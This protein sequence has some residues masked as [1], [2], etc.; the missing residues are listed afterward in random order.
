MADEEKTPN[1]ARKRPLVGK[2]NNEEV[3]PMAAASLGNNAKEEN[4]T[5]PPMQRRQGNP[6]KKKPRQLDTTPGDVEVISPPPPRVALKRPV[7]SND[8]E[9]CV[10]QSTLTNALVEYPHGR[11]DCGLHSFSEDKSKFCDKCYCLVCNKLA[12]QC[13]DWGE[14]CS[15]ENEKQKNKRTAAPA[16]HP[17]IDIEDSS[18]SSPE[19]PANNLRSIGNNKNIVNP[20]ARRRHQA[21]GSAF[22][23]FLDAQANRKGFEDHYTN[24][25]NTAYENP[26]EKGRTAKSMKITE[27]L[28]QKLAETMQLADKIPSSAEAT[29][30]S[31]TTAANKMNNENNKKSANEELTTHNLQKKDRFD[32]CK[33]EGD[34]A[35]LGLHKSFFVEGVRIGWPYPSILTPQRLMAIH[36]VKAL[37]NSRHVVLESPTGTGK[38]AAI[39]CAVLAWQRH[40]A[41]SNWGK[42]V[43]SNGNISALAA[44]KMHLEPGAETFPRIIYCSRTHSQVAQMVASLKKTPYRPRMTVLG[45]RDRLCI[46]R[47][48]RNK[49]GAT[50]G[51]NGGDQN[52]AKARVNVNT[53]CQMRVANAEKIR[54]QLWNSYDFRYDDNRPPSH[55]PGDGDGNQGD[56]ASDGED[57][58][59]GDQMQS[60]EWILKKSKK[61]LTCPHYRQLSSYRTAH[62]TRNRFAA[63]Q[64]EIQC[65]K[66][67]GEKTKLGVHE[68]ED[69]CS[70]GVNPYIIEVALYRNTGSREDFG[71]IIGNDCRIRSIGKDTPAEYCG[72]LNR[73]DKIVLVNGKQAKSMQHIQHE[74]ASTTADVVNLKVARSGSSGTRTIQTRPMNHSAKNESHRQVQVALYR[75][76][77]ETSFGMTLEIFG[78]GC[79]IS[80]FKAGPALRSR[81]V[82]V[83]DVITG[84]NGKYLTGFHDVTQEILNTAVDPLR[85]N[86]RRQTDV[87]IDVDEASDSDESDPAESEDLYSPHS[88]CPYY[89]SRALS[90]HAELLF[91]PYNYILDPGIRKALEIDLEGAVVV[92]DEAHNVEGT[93]TESGS[94]KFGEIELT[95]LFAKLSF[96]SSAA[97]SRSSK[98][99]DVT[100]SLGG[101]IDLAE[102]AH[103][104]LLFVEK[105]ILYMREQRQRFEQSPGNVGA[106]KAIEDYQRFHTPDNTDFEVSY[107]GP[108]GHGVH[109]KAVGCKPFF[110]LDSMQ[111]KPADIEK[112]LGY[113]QELE[114]QL[115]GSDKA[116]ANESN[117]GDVAGAGEKSPKNNT[118]DLLNELL[119]KFQLASQSPQHFYIS[120][121]IQANGNFDHAAG[122]LGNEDRNNAGTRNRRFQKKPANLPF[123][124]P[125]NVNNPGAALYVCN[126]DKCKKGKGGTEASAMPSWGGPGVRHGEWCDGTQSPPWEAHLVLKLLFPGL[127]MKE[128]SS[129]CRTLVLASGS[130]SP[131]KSVCA[132]LD[133]H[134]KRIGTKKPG[135]LQTTPKPLEANHVVNLEKQLLAVALGSFPNGA[136]LTVTYKHY[137]NPEFFPRLGDSIATVIETIPRGGV[138]V[139]FPSYSVLNKCVKCWSPESNQRRYGG[140][141]NSEYTCPEVW[142]RFE[143]SKTKVIVEP[144]GSNQ[145]QFEAARDEYAETI[146]SQGSCVLLAVF[147]GKMS[148]GISFNDDNARGVICVGIPFPSSK[149]RAIVAKRA[150]NDEQRKLNNNTDLLPGHDWYAQEAFRAI[151][152]A[153][154]RCIRHEGDYGTVVLMDSRHCH[155]GSPGFVHSKLPKWMR[156][157]VRT[158]APGNRGHG[159]KPILG[160]YQGLRQEMKKFFAEAPAF[161]DSV[162]TKRRADFAA[163]KDREKHQGGGGRTFDSKS[164]SWTPNTATFKS[165]AKP[166]AVSSGIG[167]AIDVAMRIT[168]DSPLPPV[169]FSNQHAA[170]TPDTPSH[171]MGMKGVV[172]DRDA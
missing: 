29:T 172:P 77:G 28:A 53:A 84:V 13:T 6:Y 88:P 72:Q 75:S 112:L 57:D 90:K 129:Q 7:S 168:Q 111:I 71:I 85:L 68:I 43:L 160:G 113:S 169:L 38:S 33:M 115:T 70:F 106:R 158:V 24:D 135:R 76:P 10:M 128:L 139:F 26:G 21:N 37:K 8:D 86:L 109:R 11:P 36:L 5:P 48:I 107:H 16:N 149:E 131:L 137:K 78:T 82:K 143:Q 87:P 145:E 18:S 162:V 141:D 22:A 67:G 153:L 124:Y 138:L 40:Y 93:L 104:L 133:L 51:D 49:G 97:K 156:Y 121:V 167:P 59:T 64:D 103:E 151:A 46:H 32:R 164:G 42:T 130:L 127:L 117:G 89:L 101:K 12:S 108:N 163:A 94:G 15:H 96:Y 3:L 63:S 45:S 56:G 165:E 34:I 52:R 44:G 54:K 161:A 99:D 116:Q 146:R 152:Q 27:I 20:H 55:L 98:L 159:N 118:F 58:A 134:D 1:A 9:V 25:F 50:Q 65:C 154:G 120:C 114:K 155:D 79:K 73:G 66:S 69:L 60:S 140:F 31:S 147:R 17:V 95:Q 102:S 157:G 39:L 61:K 62:M 80:G 30:N 105:L 83:G 126:H 47:N 92:L 110:D 81:N 41:K 4:I 171:P 142:E 91:A 14:H 136:P 150:F 170:S 144:S 2:E 125:R 122:E 19:T 166:K 74:L 23:S 35:Q 123:M 132:E 100:S 119:S 148:E